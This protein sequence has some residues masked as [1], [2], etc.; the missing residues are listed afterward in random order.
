MG[1]PGGYFDGSEFF[2]LSLNLCTKADVIA[3]ETTVIPCF[4][5]LNIYSCNCAH[6]VALCV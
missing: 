1:D 3:E 2:T 4:F 5:L 6:Y